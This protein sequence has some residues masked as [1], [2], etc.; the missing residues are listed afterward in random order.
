MVTMTLPPSFIVD[1][2]YG[3]GFPSL[4]VLCFALGRFLGMSHVWLVSG[5]QNREY[6]RFIIGLFVMSCMFNIVR[7]GT[8]FVQ[9]MMIMLFISLL[10]YGDEE[11][12]RL[13]LRMR[14][15]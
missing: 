7:G 6:T 10:M 15:D 1:F 12:R 14:R 9:S 4:L 13:F 11:A 8:G 5:L 2:L 3:F